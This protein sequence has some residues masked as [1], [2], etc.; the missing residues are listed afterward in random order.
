[1]AELDFHEEMLPGDLSWPAP[2]DSARSIF[3]NPATLTGKNFRS[4]LE[5]I[6]SPER[7]SVAVLV[8]RIDNAV[9]FAESAH[10]SDAERVELL[11]MVAHL[12][13]A[14]EI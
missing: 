2:A 11:G 9:K 3:D 4:N 14:L 1:M 13:T 5:R 8:N 7:F 10:A 12:R 6:A